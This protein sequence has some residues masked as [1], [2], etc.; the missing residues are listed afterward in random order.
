VNTDKT[1]VAYTCSSACS[2][3]MNNGMMEGG[4][5]ITVRSV[6]KDIKDDF[7][8]LAV[9]KGK[10][11]GQMVIELMEVAVAQRKKDGFL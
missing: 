9:R 3:P 5:H 8:V 2:F 10:T 4:T 7:R 11:M 1:L 6:P